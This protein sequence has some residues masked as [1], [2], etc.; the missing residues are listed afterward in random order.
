MAPGVQCLAPGDSAQPAVADLHLKAAE[1]HV[2]IQEELSA[3]PL[4]VYFDSEQFYRALLN[5]LVNALQAMDTGGVLR[6]ET[7]A[8]SGTGGVEIEISDTGI[9]M[10]ESKIEHI[11]NPF[12][13]DKQKGTGLGLSITK[14]IIDSHNGELRVTSTEHQGTTFTVVLP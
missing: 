5:I 13:T 6:V 14:N 1:Q 9:G 11:F 2:E 8:V 3:E 4:Y 12:Y 10:S 7:R